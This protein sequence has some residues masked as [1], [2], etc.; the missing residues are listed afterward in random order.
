MEVSAENTEE[1]WLERAKHASVT[2]AQ[3][4]DPADKLTMM[5]I[6]CGYERIAETAKKSGQPPNGRDSLLPISHG[7]PPQGL[8]PQRMY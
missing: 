1:Y 6:A 5:C 3:M 7:S 4:S 8:L 2:A